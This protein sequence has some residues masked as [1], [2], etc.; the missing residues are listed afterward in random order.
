MLQ[1]DRFSEDV[2]KIFHNAKGSLRNKIVEWTSN[3][4]S[5]T[6]YEHKPLRTHWNATHSQTP[7]DHAAG[8]YEPLPQ[9]ETLLSS[10]G[11]QN[12][13]S[14]STQSVGRLAKQSQFQEEQT[15]LPNKES[16]HG[17]NIND[18]PSNSAE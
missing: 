4:E 18:S 7:F 16:H 10:E 12:N 15:S 2:I 13:S 17:E 9:S 14:F 1:E 6:D 8:E 5:N 3:H 11:Y